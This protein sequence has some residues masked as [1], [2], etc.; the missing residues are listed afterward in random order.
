MKKI[1]SLIAICAM[2]FSVHSQTV[3]IGFTPV[4]HPQGIDTVVNTASDTLTLKTTSAF[5]NLTIQ[6]TVTKI[7]GTLTSNSTPQLYGSV[8]GVKYYTIAGDTLHITNTTTLQTAW[9]LTAQQ[10][11]YYQVRWTGVGTMAATIKV[12][13]FLVP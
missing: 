7:S 1:F 3:F 10:Y 4:K 6:P 11:K 2:A 8:D 5:A 12:Q 9:I 13:A